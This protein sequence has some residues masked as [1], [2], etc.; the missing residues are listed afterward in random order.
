M[1][2]TAV[3]NLHLSIKYHGLSALDEKL[4]QWLNYNNGFFVEIGANNGIDQSNTLYYEK[5]RNWR[6]I[7]IEPVPHNYLHCR[8]VRSSENTFFCNAC[9]AFDYKE[10]FVE[11][12][13]SNLMSTTVGLES[14]IADPMAH[15]LE[16]KRFLYPTDENCTFGAVAVPMET[17]LRQANA[18][19]LMDL[20]SLDVEG[21]EIEVLKGIDHAAHRFKYLC[22]ESRS[23]EKLQQYLGGI[24]YQFVSQLTGIDFLYSNAQ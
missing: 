13:Y 14:D 19:A 23:P 24:G 20:L 16:G 7:L 5:H 17:L 1:A 12:V 4:E 11:M 8:K 3:D 6:G 15:A 21:A 2:N 18:P 10:K 22:I 9:T